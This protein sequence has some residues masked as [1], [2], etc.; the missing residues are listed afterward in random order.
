MDILNKTG[1]VLE[2][3]VIKQ[4]GRELGNKKE[5]NDFTRIRYDK[6]MIRLIVIIV[7]VNTLITVSGIILAGIPA[8]SYLNSTTSS[9]EFYLI[10]AV[11]TIILL[12]FIFLIVFGFVLIEGLEYLRKL[13]KMGYIIPENRKLYQYDLRKVPRLLPEEE[14]RIKPIRSV[15]FAIVFAMGFI[16]CITYDVILINEWSFWGRIGYLYYY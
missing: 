1:M 5:F 13:K 12:S 15:V 9:S 6:K 11:A 4:R 7:V 8:S 10:V 14:V 16:M 3:L 2:K